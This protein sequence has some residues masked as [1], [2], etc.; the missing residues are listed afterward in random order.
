M[1]RKSL[2]IGDQRLNY[3]ESK[4]R[5]QSIFLIHGSSVSALQF[6][7]QLISSLGDK[8]RIIAIDLPG[9][10]YSEHIAPQNY[11]LERYASTIINAAQALAMQNAIF[12]GWSMGGN[13]CLQAW[14]HLDK[15]KG[16]LILGTSPISIPLNMDAFLP[17]PAITNAFNEDISTN[18]ATIFATAAVGPRQE[19]IQAV[20]QTILNTDA[21][22]RSQ[23]WGSIEQ[24]NYVNEI[25]IMSNSPL[26]IAVL[27]GEN[28]PFINL[29]YLR[30]LPKKNLWRNKIHVI[31]NAGH[32]AQLTHAEKFNQLLNAFAIDVN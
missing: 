25:N 5:G 32:A 20:L 14:P 30:D 13:I 9:H 28:D 11:T 26:P 10:G 18:E 15:A 22:A 17:H 8:Y 12:V 29:S 3:Y 6:Q 16:L 27:H 23:L 4:G 31:D 1:I 21:K 19:N 2:N 7:H 24:L